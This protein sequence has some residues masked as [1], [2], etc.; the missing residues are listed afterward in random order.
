MLGNNALAEDT[1]GI[2][3]IEG[4]LESACYDDEPV[5]VLV[6]EITI[7]GLFNKKVYPFALNLQYWKAIRKTTSINKF[8]W[9]A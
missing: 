1:Q 5:M 2:P 6:A 7:P 3:P 8:C 9:L 4:S